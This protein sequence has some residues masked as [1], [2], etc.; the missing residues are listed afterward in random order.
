M[1]VLIACEESQRICLEYRKYNIEAYSADIK[2][3][4]GNHP[5][6][7]ILGDVLSIINGG[8]FYTMDNKYHFIDKWDLIIAHPPCTYLSN[9]ATRLH[10]IKCNS[11][12]NINRRTIERIKAM[13]FFIQIAIADCNRIAIENPIGVMNTAYR[14]PDQ[15]IE[16]YQFAENENDIENY[17]TKSTCLWL[18][19]LPLLKTNNLSKPDNGK[20]FGYH[21]NGTARCWVE[22]QKG[23]KKTNRSKT[24]TGI[25]KAIAAQW[26]F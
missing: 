14:K 26:Q 22:C 12:E 19:N 1:K 8:S 9:V 7:H 6:Y 18:K 10:S 21:P 20:I 4:S 24:F 17:V 25:A 5:E 15:I 3:P 13:N 11:I 23:D 16:P 2:E